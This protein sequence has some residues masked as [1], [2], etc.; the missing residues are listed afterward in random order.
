MLERSPHPGLTEVF[1]ALFGEHAD[2]GLLRLPRDGQAAGQPRLQDGSHVELQLAADSK[3]R[4]ERTV[5]TAGFVLS[6]RALRNA[7]AR[8]CAPSPADFCHLGCIV[9]GV[10]VI[11][12]VAIWKVNVP[13]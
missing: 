11:F 7:P 12:L 9:T 13:L 6:T 3:T 1:V 4:I 5:L 10:P 8:R 2:Q